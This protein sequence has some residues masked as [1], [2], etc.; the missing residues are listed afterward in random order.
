MIEIIPNLHPL[1]VHFPIALS[2]AALIFT[3]AARCFAPRPWAQQWAVVGHWTLW[4]A[5]LT[6][7]VAAFFGWLAFHSVEHD[8]AGH[9]AM[10]THRAWALPSVAALLLL[11]GWDAWRQPAE[12]VNP[13]WFVVLLAGVVAAISATAWYGAELVYRHGLGVIQ[14]QPLSAEGTTV[15]VV[16]PVLP[17]APTPAGEALVALPKSPATKP[18]HRHRDGSVHAH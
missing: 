13:W 6:A 9:V 10:L 8:E 2:V 7:V 15:L 17:A 16:E 11:A 18:G 14:P 12:R 5:A 4:L 3:F 1:A